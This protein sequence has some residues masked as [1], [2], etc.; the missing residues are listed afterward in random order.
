[1]RLPRGT[2]SES[3]TAYS[4][5]FRTKDKWLLLVFS[6]IVVFTI[7]IWLLLIP[8]LTQF[9]PLT[10]VNVM[11]IYIIAVLGLQIMTGYCCQLNPGHAAFMK[12]GHCALDHPAGSSDKPRDKEDFKELNIGLSKLDENKRFRYI[13]IINAEND[14]WLNKRR[15]S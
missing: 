14:G 1:M 4:A 8:G 3:Y 6:L 12:I 2:F 13:K 9:M 11:C 7:P 5:V 15:I 10:L